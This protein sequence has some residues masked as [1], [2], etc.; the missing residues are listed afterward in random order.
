MDLTRSKTVPMIALVGVVITAASLAAVD[1]S[2]GA[3]AVSVVAVLGGVGFWHE[4]GAVARNLVRMEFHA[5][6]VVGALASVFGSSCRSAARNSP[7]RH[8]RDAA[9]DGPRSEE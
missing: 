8:I 5:I 4:R 1:W 3:V 6:T 7:T 9:P 2:A